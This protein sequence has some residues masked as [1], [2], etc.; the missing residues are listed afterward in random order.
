MYL[1]TMTWGRNA[2]APG[3]IS[4]KAPKQ[5]DAYIVAV[6]ERF[7]PGSWL[8]SGMDQIIKCATGYFDVVSVK[9]GR[10]DYIE[11]MTQWSRRTWELSWNSLLMAIKL[12]RYFM[13][14]K[15]FYFKVKLLVK[16]YNRECFKRE[17][18]D[19]Q[20]IVLRKNETANSTRE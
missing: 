13:I 7:Y 11:T 5:S 20:R 4:L 6:A 19:H 16:S 18:M 8:P 10:L 2:P 12:S 17:I 15:D 14:D 9:N 1:Q 3:D